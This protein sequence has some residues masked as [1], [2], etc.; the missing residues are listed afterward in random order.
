MLSPAV[1]FQVLFDGL[2]AI[3]FRPGDRACSLGARTQKTKIQAVLDA[4][5]SARSHS[6]NQ[7]VFRM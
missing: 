4:M 2:L 7:C 1:S 5:Q 6:I 3:A